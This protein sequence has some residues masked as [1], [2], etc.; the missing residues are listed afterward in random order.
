MQ[1]YDFSIAANGSRQIDAEGNYFR[2]S[3]GNAGGSDPGLTLRGIKSGLTITLYPG[4]AFRL[5]PGQVEASWIVSNAA[6]QAAITGSVVVGKGEITDNRISG[7]VEVIDGGKART[8]AARVGVVAGQVVA[9]GAGLFSAMGVWNPAGSGKNI[10]V[11]RTYVSSSVA[12]SVYLTPVAAAPAHTLAPGSHLVN[13]A[14]YAGAAL[15]AWEAQIAGFYG[16][17]QGALGV[18]QLAAGAILPYLLDEP[19]VIAPG[20][21]VLAVC[22]IVNTDLNV[23]M[24]IYEESA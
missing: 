13:G 2:Y 18:A 21:G 8:L 5:A 22:G 12:Q 17:S 15:A 20:H 10:I 9:Q 3:A 4:Q 23:T 6:Q 19:W 14:A 16:A 1:T 11:K 7:Q 24:P